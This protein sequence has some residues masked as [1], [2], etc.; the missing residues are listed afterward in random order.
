L[1]FL[2]KILFKNNDPLQS[3]N[4]G[5][6]GSNPSGRAISVLSSPETWVTERT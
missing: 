3:T 5:V 6:G 2:L 4:L 1:D